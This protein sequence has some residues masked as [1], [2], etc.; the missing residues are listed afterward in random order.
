MGFPPGSTWSRYVS[1][2]RIS[3]GKRAAVQKDCRLPRHLY[4]LR[5]RVW[6]RG[7]RAK[8]PARCRIRTMDL[9][10]TAA[11]LRAIPVTSDPRDR[12]RKHDLDQRAGTAP[13]L[14]LEFGAVGFDQGLGQRQAD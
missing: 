8:R 12:V 4:L 10:A 5:K 2:R 6:L 14:D 9:R 13:G 1:I 7:T 11:S 3:A